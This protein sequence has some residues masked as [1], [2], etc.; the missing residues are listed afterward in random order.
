[1]TPTRA[2][3]SPSTQAGILQ[4]LADSKYPRENRAQI[5]AQHGATFDEAVALTDANG[6]PSREAMAKAAARIRGQAAASALVG[7]PATQADTDEYLEVPL[8]RLVPDPNNVRE[9]VGD[10]TEL[11][12]SIREIGL[13]QPIVARRRGDQLV[14]VMGHRRRAAAI[15]AGLDSVPVII[16]PIRPDD[17]LVAMLIENTQREDLDPI[18]EARALHTLKAKDDLSDIQLAKRIGKSQPYVSSRLALLELS[19]EQQ[20]AI[21]NGS[22]SLARGTQV[23]RANSGKE[24]RGAW[25][26]AT[27]HLSANHP[28]AAAVEALCRSLRHQ[29]HAPGRVGGIA[30]GECWEAVIRS[31]E[32][33]RL[34]RRRR[35][36]TPRVVDDHADTT[37]EPQEAHA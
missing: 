32:A 13:L 1:V 9:K 11:A 33:S 22:M 31:D 29:K 15:L 4:A 20:E 7:E 27:G 17:V 23:G 26:K 16:R 34:E 36:S 6:F 25:G 21:R 19:A 35:G 12:D 2:Q 24:R 14:V 30:C 37:T 10:L 28:L 5:A 18:E 3:L 8:R